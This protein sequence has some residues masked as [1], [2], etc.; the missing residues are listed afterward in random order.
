MTVKSAQIAVGTAPV[1]VSM[2]E[3]DVTIGSQILIRNV[4]TTEVFIGGPDVTTGNGFRLAAAGAGSE[5]SAH[6]I[7]RSTNDIF[8]A[9]TGVSGTVHVLYVGV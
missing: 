1:L 8:Y 3:E 7:Q 4:G 6:Q 2:P 5:S 9:V